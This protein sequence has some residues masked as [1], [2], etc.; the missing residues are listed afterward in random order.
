MEQTNVLSEAA[1]LRPD[2]IVRHPGGL[3]VAVE[4]EYTPAHTVEQDAR[5]RLGKTLLQTGE[6]IEQALAVRIPITLASTNQ[7]GLEEEIERAELEFCIF[8][9]S[10]KNPDRWPATGWLD[11]GVD[12]LAGYIELAALSENRIAQGMENPGIRDRP[13]RWQAAR[14][15]RRC[16]GHAG[17]HRQ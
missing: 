3:P 5:Q 2:L 9:G 8:S 4:T 11:G 7:N 1:K 17:S 12:D 10:P 14:C 13:G 15:L 6:S 16:A